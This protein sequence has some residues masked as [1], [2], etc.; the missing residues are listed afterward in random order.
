[1]DG[2]IAIDETHMNDDPLVQ[3]ALLLSRHDKVVCV[4]F[5]VNDVL[6]INPCERDKILVLLNMNLCHRLLP[7]I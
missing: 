3:Q 7:V 2:N 5:V 4:V 6:K 1:V